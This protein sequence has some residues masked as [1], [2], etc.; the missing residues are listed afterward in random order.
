MIRQRAP[1]ITKAHVLEVSLFM[2]M[3]CSD[4]RLLLQTGMGPSTGA[5][6]AVKIT[7]LEM[8]QL[9]YV[10]GPGGSQPAQIWLTSIHDVAAPA[11][12]AVDVPFQ[13]SGSVR[14]KTV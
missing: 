13:S 3:L 7:T 14:V 1:L 5:L 9:G 4:L 6:I 2:V 10:H 8:Q 11:R 12:N